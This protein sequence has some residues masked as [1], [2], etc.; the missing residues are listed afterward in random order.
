MS[1]KKEFSLQ[2]THLFIKALFLILIF[3]SCSKE[4]IYHPENPPII[5]E[6]NPNTIDE[7]YFLLEKNKHELPS[8]SEL[9]NVRYVLTIEKHIRELTLNTF[10]ATYFYPQLR[11]L[12]GNSIADIRTGCPCSSVS[13][14]SGVSTMTL[15]YSSCATISGATYDGTIT[16]IIDGPL[17]TAGTTVDITLSDNFTIDEGD[18]DGSIS[19]EYD[20]VGMANS[21]QIN[22]LNLTNTTNGIDL[23][24]VQIG[25]GFGGNIRVDKVG[26]NSGPL[27]LLD[28]DFVY[29]A[30]MLE[31]SCPDGTGLTAE[32]ITEV[33]YNV[34]CGVPEDGSVQLKR[35][36]DNSDYA[37]IDFAYTSSATPGSCDNLAVVYLASDPTMP[38]EV[39]IE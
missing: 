6:Q 29:N 19:M 17:E 20:A 18:T 4:E 22:G 11:G 27:D 38:I 13:T 31:V 8:D 37:E 12:S 16:V 35:Q 24:E 2:L 26:T 23:T 25:S 28:D 1:C 10:Y 3:S 9:K 33:K 5:P 14:V 39:E 34:L 15:D 36:F 30:A 7:P 32:I 21:Y